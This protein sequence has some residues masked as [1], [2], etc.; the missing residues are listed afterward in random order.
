MATDA[1]IK[2]NRLNAQKSTGPK[3][4]DGKAVVARNAVKHGLFAQQN[5]INCETGEDFDDFRTELFAGLTP[6]G[7]VE[8]MMAE[9]IVSLS[10]RLKRVERMH[11]EAIDVLIAR[12]E[13]DFRQNNRRKE[14]QGARD[15]RAGGLELILGWATVHDFSESK[16]LERLLIYEKRIESSLYKAMG[17]LQKIQRVR[18][19]DVEDDRADAEM[20]VA[21]LSVSK[22]TDVQNKANRDEVVPSRGQDA[23]ATEAAARSVGKGAE[24]AKQSQSWETGEGSR[25]GECDKGPVPSGSAQAL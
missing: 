22:G 23:L 18:R 13:T 6:V 7:G 24:C 10:W 14:A 17:E 9:R 25:S 4:A 8:T 15:P 19:K 11:S 2:A 1:Q 5:V 16:V 20:E 3:T 21:T 12:A